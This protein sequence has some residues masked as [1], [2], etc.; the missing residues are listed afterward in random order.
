MVQLKPINYEE[1]ARYLGYGE[2]KPDEVILSLMKE[3]EPELVEVCHPAY[4]YGVFD[5]ERVNETTV[6]LKECSLVLSGREINQHLEG[7]TKVVLLAVTLGSGV[8]TLLRQLQITNMPKALVADA[9]SGAVIEQIC[10]DVQE[11]IRGLLPQFRQ[12]WRFSPGYGDLP[13]TIQEEL[14]SVVEAGKRIG[15]ATTKSHMLTPVKSV[16]AVIGLQDMNKISGV[17]HLDVPEKSGQPE[18]APACGTVEGCSRCSRSGECQ[19]S[20]EKIK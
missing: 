9:L 11:E 5:C 13:L 1:A 6:A 4:S 14:L 20:A 12:T 7:C 3:A 19:M 17:L 2:N 8:D 10:N 18:Q 16:T 15:L